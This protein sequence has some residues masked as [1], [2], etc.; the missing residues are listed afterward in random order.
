M[1]WIFLVVA[2]L[3][4]MFGVL[5]INKWH[6]DSN[7]KSFILLFA[8]FGASFIFLALA[9]ENITEGNHVCNLDWNRCIWWRATRNVLI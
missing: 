4:E 8:G 6:K 3:F 2:G 1:A 7:W 5:M 9:N